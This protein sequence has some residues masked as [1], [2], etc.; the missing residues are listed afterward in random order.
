MKEP[1][2]EPSS[3]CLLE[4]WPRKKAVPLF[5]SFTKV[6]VTKLRWHHVLV[7]WRA[8]RTIN[9]WLYHQDESSNKPLPVSWDVLGLLLYSSSS[10][11]TA[12]TTAQL[13]FSQTHLHLIYM[14]E[15][16]HAAS[17]GQP[18]LQPGNIPIR[19]EVHALLQGYA[20]R[21]WVG[22]LLTG[23]LTQIQINKSWKT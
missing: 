23:L 1:L 21:K 5:T 13:P 16:L 17:P 10:S 22:G 19:S 8:G 9:S 20:L 3:D 15:P 2:T 7:S 14:L 18:P 11:G 12:P 4:K 6:S